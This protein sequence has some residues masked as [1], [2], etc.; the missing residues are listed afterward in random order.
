MKP[1]SILVLLCLFFLKPSFAQST[2]NLPIDESSGRIT[3]KEVVT[4]SG[5]KDEFFDRMYAW[6]KKSY[7]NISSIISKMDKDN[8]V[9]E[10][11]LKIKFTTTDKK[12][13][14]TDGGTASYIFKIEMKEGRYRIIAY[15]FK[16][17]GG[18]GN[19]LEIWF[20]DTTPESIAIHSQ[21]FAQLDAEVKKVIA[22]LKEGMKP[23]VEVKDEW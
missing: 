7:P 14:I 1:K 19:D 23:K 18:Y 6:T 21:H 22:S 17:F 5:T 2:Y 15:D 4:E 11:N 12:G 10:L 3:Y 16:Q 8:G 20:K 9:F 13:K